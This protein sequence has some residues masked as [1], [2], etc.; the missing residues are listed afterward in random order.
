MRPYLKFVNA[1]ICSFLARFLRDLCG[2]DGK[3]LETSGWRCPVGM[4]FANA[5]AGRAVTE[6][7]QKSGG[8]FLRSF[9]PYLDIPVDGVSDPAFQTKAFCLGC[10]CPPESDALHTPFYHSGKRRYSHTASFRVV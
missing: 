1:T 3:T 7:G 5:G 8:V 9:R 6:P 2:F 10:R 4:H